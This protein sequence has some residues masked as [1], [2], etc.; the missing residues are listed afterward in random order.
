MSAPLKTG[1][2]ES[3]PPRPDSD[4]HQLPV[5]PDEE[6]HAFIREMM[7]QSRRTTAREIERLYGPVEF[8]E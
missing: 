7:K 2:I 1:H 5:D 8:S 4:G 6:E 3:P